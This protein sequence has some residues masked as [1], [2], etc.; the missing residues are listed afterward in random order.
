MILSDFEEN[1]NEHKIALIQIFKNTWA[2][3]ISREAHRS[4]PNYAWIRLPIIIGVWF[5][6]YDRTEP[7]RNGN[8]LKNINLILLDRIM[9]TL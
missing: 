4:L 2:V 6:L 8:P 1:K 3:E 9:S 5:S 7:D